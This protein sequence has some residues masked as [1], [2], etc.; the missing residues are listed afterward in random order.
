MKKR[1]DYPAR[2][3]YKNTPS[4]AEAQSLGGESPVKCIKSVYGTF[5]ACR[6]T[7]RK[8]PFMLVWEELCS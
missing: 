5:A 8:K 3:H 2:Y 6:T 1:I 4:Q 7:G